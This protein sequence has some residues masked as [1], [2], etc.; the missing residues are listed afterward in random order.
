MGYSKLDIFIL[1]YI[2]STGSLKFAFPN[3][4]FEEVFDECDRSSIC[5]RTT[6]IKVRAD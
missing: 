6:E 1:L 3:H 5:D 2:M 4:F